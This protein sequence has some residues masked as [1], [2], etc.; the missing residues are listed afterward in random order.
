MTANGIS[1]RSVLKKG[2]LATGALVV[3]SSS[4]AAAGI[5]DGRVAHYTLNNIH[6][7]KDTEEKVKDLVFDASTYKNH[8]TWEGDED[9]PMVKDGAI[10]NA[11]EFDGDDYVDVDFGD[12][13]EIIYEDWTVSGWIKAANWNDSTR[14]EWLSITEDRTDYRPLDFVHEDGKIKHYRGE[15]AG[16]VMAY[17][18]SDVSGW[19]HMLVTQ[20]RTSSDNVDLV[21]Y[22][23]GN[24]VDMDSGAYENMRPSLRFYMGRIAAASPTSPDRFYWD[25]KLD[26]VRVYNRALSSS[27]ITDLATMDEE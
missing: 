9:D 8:G 16:E 26:E 14:K 22:F 27:E 20:K 2:A 18:V 24:Q 23:D 15:A 6:M 10:G 11:Y 12:G 5:G 21:M 13:S 4:T 19:H 1:R 17:D 3:G 25:G 7:N